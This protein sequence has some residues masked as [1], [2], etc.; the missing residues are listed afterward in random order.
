MIR[1]TPEY[2]PQNPQNHFFGGTIPGE[3]TDGFPQKGFLF[4]DPG[5][6]CSGN[7]SK[8]WN[9]FLALGPRN[10]YQSVKTT[11]RRVSSDGAHSF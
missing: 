1:E 9:E 10:A 8:A 3:F 11:A 7:V 2:F 6:F 5:M 4:G